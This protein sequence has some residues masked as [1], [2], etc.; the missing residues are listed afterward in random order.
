MSR[1]GPCVGC[2]GA[3]ARPTSTSNPPESGPPVAAEL[4]AEALNGGC[5]CVTLDRPTLAAALD[6]EAG[7]EGFAD[8]LAEGSPWLFAGSPVFVPAPALARMAGVVRAVEAAARLA[9]YREAALA[10]A[11]TLSHRDFGPAGAMMGYDFHITPDG[12]KLIE[13]NTNAGGAFLNAVLARAQLACC[14]G[15]GPNAQAPAEAA[16]RRRVADMFQAEWRRQGR[17]GTLGRLAILDDAPEA[18][19][20]YPEFQLAKALLDSAGLETV[21]G[22]PRDLV[23]DG[24][25]ASLGGRPVDLVYNRLTDFALEA[26]EHGALRRAYELDRVVVT[27]N[28]HN[29]A[30]FADKRNLTLLCDLDRLRAWGLG[31]EALAVL[32]GTVL[33][34]VVVTPQNVERLWS[35]R[36]RW[37]F[38]PAAGHASKAAY[39]GDK[40]TR[41]VWE[42]ICRAPYVAQ[43]YAAPGARRLRHDGEP[44]ELK[45]DVRLYAYAGEALLPAARLYRGQTTNMRTPGGGFA[46]V[47]AV[48]AEPAP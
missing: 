47:L 39:R 36:R 40:L 10:W 14:G 9:G 26:P 12:P 48:E 2:D 11:P 46:P 43:A 44:V 23:F 1:G 17:R 41:R 30:L 45:V 16:F 27:P 33:E 34:T 6:R 35:E 5:F 24:T 21:I 13:I 32:A 20:L 8:A 3:S 4:R 7:A 31:A 19:P 15:R 25:R 22:D 37:F 29:H 38:K 42:E 28:P 18:Q